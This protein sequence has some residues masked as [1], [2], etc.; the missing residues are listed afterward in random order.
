MVV[1]LEWVII[2][3]HSISTNHAVIV[4][5]VEKHLL[6]HLLLVHKYIKAFKTVGFVVGAGQFLMGMGAKVQ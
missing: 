6:Q 3:E 4:N 2:V 1:I 5:V